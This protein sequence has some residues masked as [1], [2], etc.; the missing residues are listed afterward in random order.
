MW[1]KLRLPAAIA[2]VALLLSISAVACN[3]GEDD[4]PTRPINDVLNNTAPPVTPTPTPRWADGTTVATVVNVVD[5]DTIDVEIDGEQYRVRYIGVN[6]PET[7]DPRRPVE[8]FGEEASAQNKKLVAGKT[9]GLLKDVSETDQYGRL[10]R[11]V[12]LTP[13]D[14]V[15]AMLVKDGYAESTAY[16]PD[17]AYQDLFDS[18]EEEARNAGRGLWG[19]V[20]AETATPT[21]LADAIPGACDYSGTDEALIKGNISSEGEKIYHVPGGEFYDATQINESAGERWFCTE[22]DAVSAGWRKSQR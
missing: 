14:M 20:C 5:G 19:D 21:A 11:Y 17:V 8:C 9:V 7:V 18:L 3:N 16:P 1:R 13:K 12:W 4:R 2:A 22:S 10:L 6:T 15:N